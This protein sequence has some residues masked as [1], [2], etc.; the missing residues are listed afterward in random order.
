MR[1]RLNGEIREIPETESL[2]DLLGMLH[3]P[4]KAVL[5]ERN[6]RPVARSEF[7]TTQVTDGDSIEIVRMVAGG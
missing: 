7:A 5:V 6:G 4:D 1:L 2:L 3:L